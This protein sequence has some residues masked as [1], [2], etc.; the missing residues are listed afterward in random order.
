MILGGF[1]YREGSKNSG[2]DM[3]SCLF[4]QKVDFLGV[5]GGFD[6]FPIGRGGSK[7]AVL[8]YME[9]RRYTKQYIVTLLDFD[10]PLRGRWWGAVNKDG[11]RE[12]FS[13]FW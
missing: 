13:R 6:A 7:T 2:F 1:P 4:C 5:L 8:L 11:D 12:H 10:P 3:V 9:G